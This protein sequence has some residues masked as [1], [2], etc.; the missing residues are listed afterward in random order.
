MISAE[1][2]KKDKEQLEKDIAGMLLDIPVPEHLKHCKNIRKFAWP[3]MQGNYNGIS[4]MEVDPD[5]ETGNALVCRVISGSADG[6]VHDLTKPFEAGL[7][8]N[9]FGIYSKSD[10]R[11]ASLIKT[12]VPQDEKYHWYKIK[13]FDFGPGSFLWGFY[14]GLNVNLSSAYTAADGLP[15]FNIWETWLSVKYAGPAYVKDSKQKNGVFLDRVIL[16]KPEES[17]K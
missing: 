6:S 1:C 4:K 15:G 3:Q 8:P 10:K 11:S 16:V 14:W 7:Y 17:K 9:N 5:S 13:A 2:Q 12:D